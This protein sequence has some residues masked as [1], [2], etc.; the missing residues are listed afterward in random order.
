MGARVNYKGERN[1]NTQIKR[2][3]IEDINFNHGGK[4][5]LSQVKEIVRIC[6]I[7]WGRCN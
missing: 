7:V 5:S 1:L 3:V 4:A 6:R 2:M